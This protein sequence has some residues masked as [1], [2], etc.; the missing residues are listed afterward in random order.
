[1]FRAMSH[2]KDWKDIK[3]TTIEFLAAQSK[4]AQRSAAADLTKIRQCG[5]SGTR[6]YGLI[7]NRSKAFTAPGGTLGG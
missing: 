4:R 2:P 7:H 1:M 3:I 6:A 5:C